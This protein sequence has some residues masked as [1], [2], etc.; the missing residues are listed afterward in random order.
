MLLQVFG[1]GKLYL[2]MI[3]K[4]RGAQPNLDGRTNFIDTYRHV[5][6]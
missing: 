2:L 4:P 6:R 1:G 3:R 5:E